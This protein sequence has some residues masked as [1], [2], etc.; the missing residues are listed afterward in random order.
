MVWPCC[1][2]HLFLKRWQSAP[3]LLIDLLCMTL[4]V[5][6][7]T[8]NTPHVLMTIM[9]IG[10]KSIEQSIHYRSVWSV[11]YQHALIIFIFFLSYFASYWCRRVNKENII[12]IIE[13]NVTALHHRMCKGCVK[14]VWDLCIC[15]CLMGDPWQPGLKYNHVWIDKTISQTAKW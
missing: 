6:V 10:A 15:V 2:V 1:G 3:S 11:W 8:S 5:S 12:K 4:R 9:N 13:N 7:S 14:I